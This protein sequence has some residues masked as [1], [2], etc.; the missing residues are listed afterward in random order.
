[1]DG[2][3]IDKDDYETAETDGTL[4]V[5]L[6]ASYLETL[7]EDEHVITALFEQ[8][9]PS[10]RDFTFTV[11]DDESMLMNPA[12]IIMHDS[13]TSRLCDKN[14]KVKKLTELNIGNYPITKGKGNQ[15]ANGV[16]Y[17]IPLLS[18]YLDVIRSSSK[19]AVIEIKDDALSEEA[20]DKLIEA[21]DD[22]R[23]GTRTYLAGFDKPSMLTIK[24][25]LGSRTDIKLTR[26]LGARDK[27]NFEE[28]IE[29]C[30]NNGMD[31]VSISK[32]YIKE[33]YVKK[34]HEYGMQAAAWTVDDKNLA[35]DLLLMGCD[36]VTTN[37]IMW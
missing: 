10:E 7:D 35:A 15:S 19:T 18:D 23:L 29:W 33:A 20:A 4:R 31:Q 5:S 17:K 22:Q 16:L 14:I 2:E 30:K 21:V 3:H 9:D 25:K 28:E 12:L 36:Y 8:G 32:D 24:K 6:K 37:S 34:I 13:D 27:G 1:M 26:F 11:K